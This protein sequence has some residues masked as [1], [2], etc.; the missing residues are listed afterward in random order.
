MVSMKRFL[1]SIIIVIAS[2][3][4]IDIAIGVV[5]NH[6]IKLASK[7]NYAGLTAIGNYNLN[8]AS[9]DIVIIGSSTAS[10]HYDPQVFKD[11]L[12]QFVGDGASV[13]NA[14]FHYQQIPYSYCLLKSI[15]ERKI[16]KIAIVDIQPQNLGEDV[17]DE[18]LKV[19]R[20][21]Y[22]VNKNVKEILDENESWAN[23]LLM[24]SNMFRLNTEFL[25]ILL[26][27]T[28]PTGFNGFEKK[29]GMVDTY[30]LDVKSDIHPINSE[31]AREFEA[32]ISLAKEM[33]ISLF[34][35]MSPRLSYTDKE[36]ESYRMINTICEKYQVPFFDYS[37][38][39]DF[40]KPELFFDPVHMNT[41]GADLLSKKVCRDINMFI[42]SQY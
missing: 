28:K 38:D 27:F 7:N 12:S 17:S 1:I 37:D 26:S 15:V 10:C 16:P 9:A 25:K 31:F 4:I 24:R 32:M 18:A 13:I 6:V 30:S 36:S 20:P 23:K 8:T 19:L 42:K 34:I 14:G 3:V 5:F 40:L 41:T 33:G 22:S 21:Y 29:D 35:C 11:S 2:L 39:S